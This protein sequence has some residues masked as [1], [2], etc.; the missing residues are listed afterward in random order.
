MWICNCEYLTSFSS[1]PLIILA[2]LVDLHHSSLP[3][4]AL[5]Q[6]KSNTEHT[7][8]DRM[9]SYFLAETLKYLYLLFDS[10]SFLSLKPTNTLNMTDL[11]R[12]GGAWHL[13]HNSRLMRDGCSVGR[14]GYVFTTEAHP[15]DVGALHCCKHKWI[16]RYD[17]EL[18]DNGISSQQGCPVP[19]FSSRLELYTA[20][21]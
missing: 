10:D 3:P 9:E 15:I 1:H 21:L 16:Q 12:R 6:V 8:A 19:P 17:Q 20:T 14:S 7:L 18:N 11:L 4:S 5:Q 2:S 13:L